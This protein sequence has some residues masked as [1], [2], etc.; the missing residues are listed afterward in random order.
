[1]AMAKKKEETRI[2]IPAM[3]ISVAKVRIVGDSPLISHAWSEKAKLMMLEKQMKKASKGKEIRR[4]MVE[5]ANSLYWLSEKP[6][7]DSMTDEEIM[8]ATQNGQ[9]GF[10][11]LAFKAA[12]IDASYQ[13]GAIEKKT[14]MRASFHLEGEFATIE[15]KPQLREDMARIGMGTA[16]LRYRAMFEHWATT[17]TIR[18]NARAVSLEQIINCLN[19]GGF[20]AG[21]GDWRPAKDGTY[22]QFHCE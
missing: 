5:Y 12:A 15:G 11:V 22:G 1:M 20:G 21:V 6:D 8:E 19:I 18:Y 2:E 9:F 7:F 13:S 17:L 10:P 3:E 16:D 14:T 4:P